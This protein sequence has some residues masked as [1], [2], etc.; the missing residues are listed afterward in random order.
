MKRINCLVLPLSFCLS[1]VGF[2]QAVKQQEANLAAAAAGI[3]HASEGHGS[4]NGPDP[5]GS[6]GSEGATVDGGAQPNAR[7]NRYYGTVTLDATRVGRD[8]GRILDRYHSATV[9]TPDRLGYSLNVAFRRAGENA[10]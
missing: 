2:A 3:G 10:R 4:V 6:S 5:I 9:A 8:A 1:A 7:P